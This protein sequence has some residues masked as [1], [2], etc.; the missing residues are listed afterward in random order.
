MTTSIIFQNNYILIGPKVADFTDIN[1]I[2]S[3]FIKT[4]IKYN[5]NKI[6]QQ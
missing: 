1:K 6:K 4:I 5:N 2:A 3:M